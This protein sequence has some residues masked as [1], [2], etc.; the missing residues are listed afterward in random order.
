MVYDVDIQDI[1]L[2]EYLVD[3]DSSCSHFTVA[4]LNIIGAE[5]ESSN[6]L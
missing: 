2:T 6:I 5:H 1:Q 3:F 4:Q